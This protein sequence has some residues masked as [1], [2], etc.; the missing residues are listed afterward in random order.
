[1][2][3]LG[4]VGGTNLKQNKTQTYKQ[5]QSYT[6]QFLQ[7]PQR[8]SLVKIILSHVSPVGSDCL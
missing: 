6:L 5:Q 7:N 3:D 2:F 1:M 4:R 8:M